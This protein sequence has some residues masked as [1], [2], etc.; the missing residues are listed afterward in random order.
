MTQAPGSQAP[1]AWIFD[2]ATDAAAR[3][4]ADLL[5]RGISARVAEKPFTVQGRSFLPGTILIRREGNPADTA[6]I[7]DEIAKKRQVAVQAASTA[8][9]DQGADLGGNY[10]HPLVA[11]RVGVFAGPLASSSEYGAIWHDL[12]TDLGVR[13]TAIDL[14]N[15]K[16]SD[17]RRYNVLILPSVGGSGSLARGVLGKEGLEALKR[18]VEA[19]GTLIGI[20]GGAELL[21]EKDSGL[22]ATRLRRQAQDVAPSPVWSISGADA[23]AAAPIAA[24]GLSASDLAEPQPAK[25]DAKP[26]KAESVYDVAPVIGPGARPFVEGVSLGTPLPGRPMELDAWI[27]GLLP[28]G[29]DKPKDDDRRRADTRLRSFSPAGAFLRIDL[30]SDLYLNWG[31]PAAMTAWVGTEDTLVA[32][33]PARA[34]ARFGGI[35]TIHQGGLLWPEAAARLAKTAYATRESLGRGQVVLFLDN[36]VFRGW[37]KGTRRML[38]NAI[39]YGPGVGAEPPRRGSDKGSVRGD[40]PR[41]A[42][43]GDLGVSLLLRDPLRVLRAR[44]LR[45]EMG[46]LGGVKNLKWMFTATFLVMLA[47]VP[48]YS[49]VVARFPRR[50][51]IPIAYRFCA[52]NIALFLVLDRAGLAEVWVAR[53]VFV[54]VSVFNVFVVSVFW[55][56]MVDTFRQDQGR[57]L[58]GAVAAGGSVGALA[59]PALAAVLVGP[60]GRPGLYVVTIVLLEFAVF[61]VRRLVTWSRTTDGGSSARRPTGRSAA[62]VFA[63]FR[64]ALRSPYLLGIAAMLLVYTIT[65][66]VVYADQAA[67]VAA[68]VTDSSERTALFARIDLGVNAVALS[69]QGLFTGWVLTALGVAAALVVLPTITGLGFI[70]LLA[71]PGL[72]T[73]VAFQVARRGLQYGLERPAREVLYT[74]VSPEEKYKAK[75]FIDTVVF[76][77][78]DAAA[79]WAYGLVQAASPPAAAVTAAMLLLCAG[80]IAVAL[81][82]ARRHTA[83]E[84][85]P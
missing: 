19:G 53:I 74:V 10:F 76:R 27:A 56:F 55:S 9:A 81:Y 43:R 44:P 37:M 54:W 4:T 85:T 32:A 80:W 13:F 77:G 31:S 83:L 24:T 49:A 28:A 51:I 75:A 15:F 61:C 40:P 58:F 47:V 20:G 18:W 7:L 60:F 2:G 35:E 73:L 16:S 11:P 30:D 39:L 82:L 57:R 64:L 78:G 84:V 22:T 79:I 42:A 67:I 52:A 12:D 38:W 25:K 23:V 14:A 17:L 45:D 50:K 8:L 26:P 48:L 63:G 69:F 62:G 5:A 72:S 70:G 1:V 41:G 3:A 6:A 71:A 29:Q 68:T 33:P 66:T 59:G 36:P 65:S 21:A 46:I 34:A